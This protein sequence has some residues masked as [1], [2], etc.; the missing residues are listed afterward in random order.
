ML[1]NHLFQ[2]NEIEIITKWI[3]DCIIG[4]SSFMKHFA[5][6]NSKQM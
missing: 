1:V 5:K 2:I 3:K 4:R 6:G